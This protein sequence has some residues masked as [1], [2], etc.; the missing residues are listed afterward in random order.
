MARLVIRSPEGRI[1]TRELTRQPIKLGRADHCD[2]VLADDAEVSR[3]H[4]EIWLDEDGQI[5]VADRGSKNGTRVDDGDMFRNTRRVAR[6]TVRIGEHSIEIMGA[7][8]RPEPQRVTFVP[9]EA[10]PGGDTQYFP[11]SRRLDLNLHRLQL[12]ISLTERI[13]GVFERKQLLEQALDAMCEALGF[14]RGL[15][16]LKT[17]RGDTEL[18]VTRNVQ[19]DETGAFKISR[20]LINRA[21]LQGERAIVNNPA[22]DLAGSLTESLVRFPICSALC[23]PILNRNEILGV[24]YGDRVTQAATYQPTDVDFLAAIAQQ[25]GVGLA[26][27]RLFQEHLRSQ[28]VYAELERAREIQRQLLPAEPLKIGG[29]TIEG[30]NEA[31]SAVSGDYFDYFPLRDG[32]VG[33]IIADVTGHGL[34]AALMMANL[35]AAVRV[36]LDADVSLTDLGDRVNKLTCRNTNANLFIT[37]LMGTLDPLSGVFE[38][39]GAGH[40]PPILLGEGGPSVPASEK[41]A[42][43][44]GIDADERYEA[45]RLELGPPHDALLFYTDGLTEAMDREGRLL[46]LP[47]VIDA[48]SGVADRAPATLIRTARGLVRRHLDGQASGDDLTLLAMQIQR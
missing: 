6:R 32:R 35:Q 10:H 9:D 3:E 15:I 46:G 12:L 19:R 5:V 16:A 14:E 11:S 1:S 22:T 37:A 44:L 17:P 28:R 26:S 40:P 33:V 24:V 36:A 29:M 8:A 39:I 27:L 45:Q 43:P 48:V 47:P 7:P 25:V 23:V 38:F 41:N 30:Y 42:L 13:G 21:L 31:S 18:P 4:A 20:T 34:A 2:V